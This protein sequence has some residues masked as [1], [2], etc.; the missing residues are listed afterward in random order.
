MRKIT[1]LLSAFVAFT[2]LGQNFAADF[3]V[4]GSTKTDTFQSRQSMATASPM[5]E[6]YGEVRAL[7]EIN[8]N[9][10]ESYPWIS[11]DGL[12]LYYSHSD[13][14]W[15]KIM[16][17]QRSDTNSEFG[18]PVEIPTGVVY[19]RSMW[20]SENELDAYVI[21]I[22][23][24]TQLY[25]LHR[26][27]VD[28]PFEAPVL[29]TLTGLLMDQFFGPSLD[30]S[31]NTMYMHDQTGDDSIRIFE[32]S[33]ATSFAYSGMLDVG[34]I[35]AQP[36]QLSKDELSY[37]FGFPPFA[38]N[39]NIGQITRTST[40]EAF[41][42]QTTAPLQ[43]FAEAT[44]Y[45]SHPTVSANNE[46]IVYLRNDMTNG[47]NSSDLYMAHNQ[48]LSVAKTADGSNVFKI[49]PNPSNGIF[50]IASNN[51]KPQNIE[52]YTATGQKVFKQS[53]PE[54]IDLSALAKGIYFAKIS[55]DDFAETTKL[56]LK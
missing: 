39:G 10:A 30:A 2:A 23:S 33:S 46:W 49:Y 45:I 44:A 6:I 40:S 43:G 28:S 34:G 4:N 19:P 32:R 53:M 38:G 42:P 35:L 36:G 50:Q 25:Y 22:G 7:T 52:V 54:T 48:N 12:R 11:S 31:Q 17:T 5:A 13:I 47:F 15:G 51:H 37:F 1:T 29:I 9:T 27:T 26:P 8:T 56:I 24:L 41:D 20:L 21:G 55:G 14:S 18:V 16:F 3:N